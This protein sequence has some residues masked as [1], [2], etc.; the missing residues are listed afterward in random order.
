MALKRSHFH[1]RSPWSAVVSSLP[2][3]FLLAH[4]GHTARP[5]VEQLE[6]HAPSAWP[7]P[8]TAH[9]L[10]ETQADLQR[11][12]AL[13]SEIRM[14]SADSKEKLLNR[15]FSA[16][17]VLERE[18]PQVPMASSS[19]EQFVSI[20]ANWSIFGGGTD[21][22]AAE[23]K[24]DE[25]QSGDAGLDQKAQ[26]TSLSKDTN[27]KQV[28]PTDQAGS[29]VAPADTQAEN[30][31]QSLTKDDSEATSTKAKPAQEEAKA[32]SKTGQG[33]DIY[34]DAA[35]QG[36]VAIGASGEMRSVGMDLLRKSAKT[37]RRNLDKYGESVLDV[38]KAMTT[39]DQAAAQWKENALQSFKDG[40]PAR[41]HPL[42]LTKAKTRVDE[43]KL[44]QFQQLV[45]EQTAQ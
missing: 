18:L 19:G 37:V 10:D 2:L 9:R 11:V 27:A 44:S 20:G 29:K 34:S 33:L 4:I 13:I 30:N 32:E 23:K 8:R 42:A 26:R 17:S 1:S 40:D 12:R 16:P 41:V 3:L 39:E 31:Q 22:H 24:L 7:S 43:A 36:D 25:L 38:K 6:A 45:N 21:Q 28:Q 5:P 14:P 35:K 15:R